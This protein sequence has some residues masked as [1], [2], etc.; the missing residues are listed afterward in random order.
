MPNLKVNT[1]EEAKLNNI[2]D[3]AL[4]FSAMIRLMKKGSKKQ[5]K[6]KILSIVNDVFHAESSTQY[7]MIHD[8][9]CNWG[10][11]SIVLA[12][13]KKN[14]LII[15]ESRPISYGQIAKILDV[16]IGVIVYYCNYPDHRKSLVLSDW[17]HAAVD[18]E[19]MRYLKKTYPF[20][21]QNW[22]ATIEKVNRDIYLSIQQTVKKYNHD[23][24]QDQITPIQFDDIYWEALNR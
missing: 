9:F 14:G 10:M 5:L 15:K 17:L 18:N 22:P 4:M 1:A 24:H 16:V 11:Q 3:M 21:L 2:V 20:E 8:N 6:D 12:E 19:M 23:K 13:K 7:D